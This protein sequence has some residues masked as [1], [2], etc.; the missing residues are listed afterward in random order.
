MVTICLC[1]SFSLFKM[2]IWL[3]QRP[4]VHLHLIVVLSSVGGK[5]YLYLILCAIFDP[6]N[7]KN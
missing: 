5:N 7:A 1:L 4:E 6:N 3:I 2:L